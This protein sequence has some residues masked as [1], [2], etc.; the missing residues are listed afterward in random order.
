V[1]FRANVKKSWISKRLPTRALLLSAAAISASLWC[2]VIHAQQNS[3]TTPA[4][5]DPVAIDT[6]VGKDASSA[7]ALQKAT[8][9]PVANLISVPIQNNSNFGVGAYNRTQNVLNI[10]P[11]IPVH[12]SKDW[13]LISRIIQPIVW[14]PYP[15][16]TTGGEFGFGDMNPTFFL[17]PAKP[18]KVI[19]G[20]GPAFVIPTATNDVLGQGK[21]SIGPSFVALAQPGHWTIGG[22]VNNVWS[23][24]G[25]GGRP[26]VNQMT[27]Q[28]FLNYNLKK[29]YYVSLSPIIT[30]DWEA[31]SGN[32]WTVPFGGGVGRIM[33]LGFQPV[34]ITAQFYGNAVHPQG[35]S[36]WGM[37]LQLALLYPKFTKE[38]EMM[39]MEKNLSQLKA[40]QTK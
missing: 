28:Y 16:E 20:A 30:A 32:T 17:S 15:N 10:Q 31:S 18:G 39:M 6:D 34:N 8:Q 4:K 29:G 37:R 9:N 35:A 22:L 7:E 40:Q 2:G 26:A 1:N 13:M 33:K 3:Q 14:Q 36:P 38:Q 11:V 23:V 21:L 27:F 5:P 25:S 24:A 12:I 19:W